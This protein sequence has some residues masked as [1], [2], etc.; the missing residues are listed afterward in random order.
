MRKIKVFLKRNKPFVLVVLVLIFANLGL[1]FFTVEKIKLGDLRVYFLDIGQGDAIFI[2][3]PTGKQVL[4]D[5]GPSRS[6]VQ[7]LS[8]IMPA[9][10]RSIDLVI[11]THPEFDHLT[12]LLEV[13]KRY[14]I[15]GIV[16]TDIGC[17][18]PFCLEWEKL[19]KKEKA[20]L[21][22]A[23]IGQEIILD[24]YTKM[25]IL[26][27]FGYL[28]GSNVSKKNNYSIVA[29][30][31]FTNPISNNMKESFLFTGD[32]EK[33]VEEKL[34]LAGL[35]LGSDFLKVPHHGS[36]TS[37]TENFLKAV[38][39]EAAFIIAGFKN[40]YH[41]PH[42]VVLDR[43]ENLSIKYYRTDIDGD[44]L[45]ECDLSLLCQVKN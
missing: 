45:V 37:S 28:N 31:I 3:T 1:Y 14:K 5:G 34:I 21:I 13:L 17:S 23:V 12:G 7:K 36:K 20:V 33:G 10:D 8:E 42:E 41:H 22:K 4:I 27:P 15:S 32:I 25:E 29:K 9:W 38:S 16:D 19:K 26:H 39:P 6:I 24:R 44:I 35:D 40:R 30:L 11:L 2:E 18:T 43:L